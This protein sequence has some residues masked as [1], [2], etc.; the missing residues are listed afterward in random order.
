M[1]NL[2]QVYSVHD[3]QCDLLELVIYVRPG[4]S[5]L[6]LFFMTFHLASFKFADEQ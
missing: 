3:L 5:I 6:H 2:V 4:V 1:H